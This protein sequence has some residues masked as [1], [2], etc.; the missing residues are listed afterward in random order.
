[1]SGD[2]D[3][4]AT[5]ELPSLGAAGGRTRLDRRNPKSCWRPT[6]CCWPSIPVG[7]EDEAVAA[8]DELGYPVVLKTEAH[9]LMHRTDLGGIRLNLENERSF[10]RHT[11]PSRRNT[12]RTSA[13]CS[14]SNGWLPA[15]VPCTVLT[16]EDPAFGPVLGFAVGGVMTDLVEDWAWCMAPLTEIDAAA[17]GAPSQDLRVALRFPGSEPA[18][19]D[20]L[21]DALRRVAALADDFPQLASLAINPLLATP[22]GAYVL[23]ATSTSRR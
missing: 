16:W 1:M 11:S 18:D 2:L 14:S 4:S 21:I 9:R 3:D 17:S 5:T 15:G 7:S 20:S 22:E 12:P 23:G 6:V 13:S 19:I 10:A 8:A